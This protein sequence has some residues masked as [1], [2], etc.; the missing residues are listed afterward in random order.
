MTLVSGSTFVLPLT[1]VLGLQ[2]VR[3]TLKINRK[4]NFESKVVFIIGLN[5]DFIF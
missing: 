1:S 5:P 4:N 3:I 2:A